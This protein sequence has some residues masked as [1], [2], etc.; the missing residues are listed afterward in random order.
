MREE[1]YR[2]SAHASREKSRSSR[3]EEPEDDKL[4]HPRHSPHGV[5]W[6]PRAQKELEDYPVMQM[7]CFHSL[8]WDSLCAISGSAD[9]TCKWNNGSGE[10]TDKRNLRRARIC[11]RNEEHVSKLCFPIHCYKTFQ[12]LIVIF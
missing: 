7:G 9:Y 1:K 2:L 6:Y 3:R 5:K 8:F 10:I 12:L 4:H 11:M